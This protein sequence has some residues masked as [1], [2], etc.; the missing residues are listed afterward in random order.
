MSEQKPKDF[1]ILDYKPIQKFI[2]GVGEDVLKHVGRDEACIIG[3]GDDGVF[4]GEG[5]YEWLKQKGTSA[6][7]TLMD[8]DCHDLDEAAVKDRKVIVV[9][10]DI[11]TGT[12]YKQVIDCFRSRQEELQFL[13]VKFAVLCDRTALA[14]FVVEGYAITAGAEMVELDSIDYTIIKA[15][16]ADGRVSFAD[17]A[18]KTKLTPAGVKKRVDKMIRDKVLSIRGLLNLQKFYSV[19]ALINVEVDSPHVAGFIESLYGLPMVYALVRMYDVHNVLVGVLATSLP[20]VHSFVDQHIH[21]ALGVKN[22]V[23]H[24]GDVPL[25]PCSKSEN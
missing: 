25:V 4:Y 21:S 5:L 14:D 15:L 17:L 3:L 22:V 24:V 18:E 12:S 7:F 1:S 8:Y 11:I 20:E 19:S 13:D 10:N 2:D 6:V 9:D 16:G 23:V